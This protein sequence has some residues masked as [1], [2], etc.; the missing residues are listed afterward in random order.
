MQDV[1][2]CYALTQRDRGV[3]SRWHLFLYHLFRPVVRNSKIKKMSLNTEP[4]S[5]A[6]AGWGAALLAFIR[7]RKDFHIHTICTSTWKRVSFVVSIKEHVQ[8]I[9]SLPPTLAMH[10]EIPPPQIWST[11]LNYVCTC[12]VTYRRRPFTRVILFPD[13]YGGVSCVPDTSHSRKKEKG[14]HGEGAGKCH[15]KAWTPGRMQRGLGW[16]RR[17]VRSGAIKGWRLRRSQHL[18]S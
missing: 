13:S 11:N 14:W 3:R 15:P 10:Q 18:V 9:G 7:V 2:R 5:P 8:T 4:K 16:P 17:G 6:R 12:T 1:F